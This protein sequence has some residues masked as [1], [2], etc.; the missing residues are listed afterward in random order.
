MHV[1]AKVIA[2][3]GLLLAL[4]VLCMA[5][6]SVLETSTLFLLAASSYFVGIVIREFGIKAGTAFYLADVLLGFIVAPNKFYVLTFAAMGFYVLAV[7]KTWDILGRC[8][9]TLPRRGIFW[10]VKYIV[11]NILY[12]PTVLFFQELLFARELP[13][14]VQAGVILVGQAGLWIYDRAYEYSQVH[15]WGRIRGRVLHHSGRI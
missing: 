12:I 6:G 13:E 9:S 11:F 8:R 4:S 3:C 7:E 14:L 5:M 1:K 10:T 2:F 15:I